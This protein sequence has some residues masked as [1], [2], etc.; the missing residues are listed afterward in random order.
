METGLFTYLAHPDLIYF[1]GDDR[2]YETHMRRLCKAAKGCDMPL[3]INMWGLHYQRNY[4][5]Q[6]FWRIVAEEGN[7]VVIGADAHEAWAVN[8]TECEAQAMEIVRKFDLNLLP[9]VELR[10]F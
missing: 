6:R 3:E 1:T 10:K 5:D 4:P 2:A 7:Q 9:T 8:N